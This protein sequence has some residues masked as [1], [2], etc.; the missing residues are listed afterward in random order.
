MHVI[1]KHDNRGGEKQE[2][3]HQQGRHQGGD[4]QQQ[5]WHARRRIAETEPGWRGKL[6]HPQSAFKLGGVA[7]ERL[8]SARKSSC[9]RLTAV[10]GLT[11]P[12]RGDGDSH[13]PSQ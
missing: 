11:G 6:Q 9:S 4:Q 13:K 2:H 5:Q 7:K 1:A 12:W 8:Q 3:Q 10:C